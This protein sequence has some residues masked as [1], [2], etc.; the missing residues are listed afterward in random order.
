MVLVI[1]PTLQV[2]ESAMFLMLLLGNYKLRVYGGLWSLN[3]FL[4][5]SFS[6]FDSWTAGHT[7][8]QHDGLVSVFVT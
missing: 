1:I 4:Y 2:R 6:W 8:R 5:K 3:Q 7:R